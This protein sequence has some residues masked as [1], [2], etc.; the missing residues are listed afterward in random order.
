MLA[1]TYTGSL[2]H[3]QSFRFHT[4]CS[5]M[6]RNWL[7]HL[8]KIKMLSRTHTNMLSHLHK[9]SHIHGT[10]SHGEINMLR[11]LN[12]VCLETH[13]HALGFT[14]KKKRRLLRFHKKSFRMQGEML[15]HSQSNALA[16]TQYSFPRK[17]SNVQHNYTVKCTECPQIHMKCFEMYKMLSH[18][19]KVLS[20]SWKFH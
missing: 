1:C 20:H 2:I 7:S 10:C 13:K 15:S 9:C 19:Q 17:R 14:K 3:I 8:H 6:D 16:G 11:D 12:T 5:H 18:S 4:T